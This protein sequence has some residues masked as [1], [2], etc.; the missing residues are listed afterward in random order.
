MQFKSAKSPVSTM[1]DD[2]SSGGVRG[3]IVHRLGRARRGFNEKRFL[4]K[5]LWGFMLSR[6]GAGTGSSPLETPDQFVL[7]I[8][9]R[10]LPVWM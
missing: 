8:K 5:P 9:D 4:L 10:Q 3:H 2:G 7:A 6:D 1:A